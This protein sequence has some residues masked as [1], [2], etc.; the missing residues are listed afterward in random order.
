MNT[1]TL[2][3]PDLGWSAFF[4]SQLSI[5]E[6]EDLRALRVIEVHRNSLET[7]GVDGQ[8]RVPMHRDL[9]EHGMAVGDWILTEQDSVQ[10]ERVLERKSLIKRG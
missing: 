3:L 4:Q 6:V 9:V 5:E 1:K 10:V 7:M 8:L 2:T